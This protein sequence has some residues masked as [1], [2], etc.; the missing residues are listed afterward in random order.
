MPRIL[1]ATK[2]E[3][4]VLCWAAHLVPIYNEQSTL[5]VVHVISVSSSINAVATEGKNKTNR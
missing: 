3:M 2:Q 4:Y 1:M 5:F